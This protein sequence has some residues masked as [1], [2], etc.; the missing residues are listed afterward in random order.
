[1]VMARTLA[2]LSILLLAG[3]APAGEP[4]RRPN[5][6]VFLVDDLGWQDTSVPFH[7]EVTPLN[8]RHRTPAMERL[9]AEGAKLV[10][11][12]ASAVCSPSRVSLLTGMSAARHGVTNWTLRRDRSPDQ[13]HPTLEMPDW[14]LN[15]LAP[16]P[17]TPRTAVARCLPDLLRA[18][19]Y[20][21]IHV[22]KAHFGAIGTPGADPRNLGFDIN[23][24]GH[25]AG[26]PGSYHGEKGYGARWR[27]DTEVWDVP[28]LDRH[29]AAGTHLTEALTLEAMA[30][31]EAAVAEG[32]PFFLH[33]SHYAVH[34]PWEV[35]PRFAA[36]HEAAGLKG[37]ELAL[38]TMVE[39]VDK[40]LAD[41]LALLDRLG[42]ARDTLV[43][44]VSDNG[45]PAEV[46][47]NLPLRGHKLSC[48]EG[49]DRVPAIIR[50]P[51]RV[52]AGIVDAAPMTIEDLFP[53]A[54]EAAGVPRGVALPQVVDGA[55]LV[56]H[57]TGGPRLPADRPLVF[58]FPNNYGGQGPFSALRLGAWRLTHHHATGRLELHDLSRDLGQADDLAA[59]R[60]DKVRELAGVLAREL[61]DRG[62]LMPRHREDGRPVAVPVPR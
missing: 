23:V 28:G 59:R 18:S 42:V 39:G 11:F 24:A 13:P 46:P 35:D 54:L 15:G 51:G 33:L 57:L 47:R 9:A 1:M 26:G 5:I 12:H 6:I 40:S 16:S 25:A 52:P 20:R 48:H 61:A 43:I 37:R 4:S 55:S 3:L 58:H 27:G 49:G 17:G 29:K 41:L 34:A 38:A 60:P 31:V 21:T 30:A 10:D 8:R 44:L 53:T 45:A 14:P 50:W 2:L 32:R 62:A 19:G 56:P 36:R 22:G 7:S